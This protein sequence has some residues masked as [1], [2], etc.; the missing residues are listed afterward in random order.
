MALLDIYTILD[1]QTYKA[2]QVLNLYCYVCTTFVTATAAALELAWEGTVLTDCLPIQS[3]GLQHVGVDVVN[4][5]NPGD[6]FSEVFTT[7]P[8]GTVGGDQLAPFYAYTF[9]YVRPTRLVRNGYKRIGGVPESASTDGEHLSGAIA[10]A[11]TALAAAMASPLTT[12]DG[13][14]FHP[15]I[16]HRPGPGHPDP[17]ASQVTVVGFTHFGTQNSRKIGRGA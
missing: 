5:N 10:A 9:Q 1:R 14:A 4:L 17:A 2:Q 13:S 15:A 3:N 6:F 12:P 7:P 11:A 8:T 16:L